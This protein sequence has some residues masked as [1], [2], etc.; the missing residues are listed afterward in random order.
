MFSIRKHC[1]LDRKCNFSSASKQILTFCILSRALTEKIVHVLEKMKCP[2]QLE[3]HQIQGMDCIHIFPVIQWLIK[4]SLETRQANANY[5]RAY[6][7]W[8]FNSQVKQRDPCLFPLN[9]QQQLELWIDPIRSELSRKYI[10]SN[11]SSLKDEEVR[12]NTT[13]LEYGVVG[14]GPNQRMISNDSVVGEQKVKTESEPSNDPSSDDV[15]EE[16]LLENM[17]QTSTHQSAPISTTTLESIFSEQSEIFGPSSSS[18]IKSKKFSDVD[19]QFMKQA[20]KIKQQIRSKQEEL[21]R[22][23]SKNIPEKLAA[24]KVS[25]FRLS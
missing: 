22:L 20:A 24:L 8:K 18:T 2:F 19:M 17:I 4:R 9:T 7:S 12:L 6:A 10:H 21:Q 25:S 13:L 16:L 11:R 23:Q 15:N 1:R 14:S 3:P 5:L